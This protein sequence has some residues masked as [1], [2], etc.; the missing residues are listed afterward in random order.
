MNSMTWQQDIE[1]AMRAF[2]EVSALAKM[3]L[4]NDCW[5]LEFS[6]SPHTRPTTLPAGKMAI[7][8]FWGDGAWLK[9]GMAGSKSQARYTSQHYNADSAPSTLSKSLLNDLHMESV[10]G[11]ERENPGEWIMSNCHRVNIIIP[12]HFGRLSLALLEAFL[13]ARLKPRYER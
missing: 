9:I 13:H 7:Y 12:A 11:F 2:V 5:K 4:T 3:P 8:G 10:I 6:P 1:A